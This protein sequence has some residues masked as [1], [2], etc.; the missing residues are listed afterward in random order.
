MEPR[1]LYRANALALGGWLGAPRPS[2][3]ESQGSLVLS[4][5]GGGGHAECGPFSH[6]GL[7]RFERAHARVLGSRPKREGPW[8]TLTTV[9]VEGLNVGEMVT[10]ERV[11]ARLVS[12]HPAGAGQPRIMPLGSTFENLRIARRPVSYD[13][14][15]GLFTELGTYEGLLRAYAGDKRFQGIA[16]RD[17]LWTGAPSHAPQEVAEQTLWYSKFKPPTPPASHGIIPAAIVGN[18]KVDGLETCGN[19]VIVPGFGR[20]MLGELL[21][22][23]ETRR[24]NMLRLDLGSPEDGAV[25]IDAAE[26]NGHKFP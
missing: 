22:G 9:T 4:I 1:F 19:V 15:S 17:L 16:K 21:I 10:A 25:V 7:I 24:L 14:L 2:I 11:V 20:V 12:Q 6:A 23:E 3:I 26:T 5:D 18:V 13:D 8:E